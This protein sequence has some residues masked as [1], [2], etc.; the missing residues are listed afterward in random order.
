MLTCRLSKKGV[1]TQVQTPFFVKLGC[2]SRIAVCIRLDMRHINKDDFRL[3]VTIANHLFQHP[4]GNGLKGPP[5]LFCF[6]P[7]TD[8]SQ[9]K[10]TL[11]PLYVVP[12]TRFEIILRAKLHFKQALIS[13]TLCFLSTLFF[14]SRNTARHSLA[15]V[16][17]DLS[18]LPDQPFFLGA[19]H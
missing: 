11:F 15:I 9:Y 6:C 13:V 8:H 19:L 3:A 2:I 1:S 7:K 17:V 4:P 16:A 18:I 10:R 14:Q 5:A 12:Q